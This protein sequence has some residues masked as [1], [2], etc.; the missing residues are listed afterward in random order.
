[1]LIVL[2]KFL[3]H[4]TSCQILSKRSFLKNRQSFYAAYT[5]DLASGVSPKDPIILNY[6]LL[7]IPDVQNTIVKSII[8]A[9][10]RYKLIITPRE[11]LD[12]LYSIIVYPL[13]DEYIDG[14]KEKK[15]FFEALLPTL[16]YCGSENMIQKQLASSIL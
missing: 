13:Y 6:E 12:F 1:M 10:V 5:A 9:I 2:L 15:E 4:L 14:H 3:L 11:Y 16:L 7:R 8:E